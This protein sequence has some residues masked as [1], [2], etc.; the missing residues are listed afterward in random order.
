ME[1]V[2]GPQV[3]PFA[4]ATANPARDLSREIESAVEREPLDRVRCVRVFGDY[5]RC[6][7]WS[8][9]EKE[10]ARRPMADWAALA[11]NRVRKS[12]FLTA[13]DRSGRLVI[14]V[15]GRDA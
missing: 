10:H 13:S 2:V 15:V 5:Y 12:R 7:W 14:E 6:N 1:E 8:P 4:A 9:P 3:V 11:M